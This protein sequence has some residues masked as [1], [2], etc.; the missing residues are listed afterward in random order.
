[1]MIESLVYTF[2]TI[3]GVD[4]IKLTVNGE[5]L[6]NFTSFQDGRDLTGPLYPA[7]FINPESVPQNN[8]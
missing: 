2:T 5:N 4:N 7:E 1:M 6:K 8:N 3:P